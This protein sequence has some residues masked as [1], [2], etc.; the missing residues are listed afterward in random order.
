MVWSKRDIFG[1]FLASLGWLKVALG[2]FL[3][4][5]IF[6]LFVFDLGVEVFILFYFI[7]FYFCELDFDSCFVLKVS[8]W[9]AKIF[10]WVYG[11]MIFLF[12]ILVK[13]MLNRCLN[14][15]T[16]LKWIVWNLLVGYGFNELY[17]HIPMSWSKL[18]CRFLYNRWWEFPLNT[19]SPILCLWVGVVDWGHG[20]WDCG[21][22]C[23][24]SGDFWDWVVWIWLRWCEGNFVPLEILILCHVFI[25]LKL[26]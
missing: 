14:F 18:S 19:L 13:L 1:G 7:L 17:I 2:H 20:P 23:F 25:I 6:L 3:D 24:R 11:L 26:N 16:F 5:F 9:Y 12:S 21:I 22:G 4:I 8:P 10:I 15:V